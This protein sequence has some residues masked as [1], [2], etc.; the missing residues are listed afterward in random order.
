MRILQD[1]HHWL[2]ARQGLHLRNERFQCSVP[3]LLKCQFEC[4]IAALLDYLVGAREQRWR[5][6][7]LRLQN[8]KQFAVPSPTHSDNSFHISES[9][10]KKFGVIVGRIKTPMH[11]LGTKI[12]C[13]P[14]SK[15]GA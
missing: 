3:A 14:R 2:L 13:W 11:Y 10:L 9:R 1:H 4:G 15:I 8:Y 7:N 5:H 6:D 12:R